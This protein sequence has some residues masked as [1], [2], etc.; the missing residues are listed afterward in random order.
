MLMISGH[1]KQKCCADK[2]CVRMFV[3]AFVTAED[4]ICVWKITHSD[5]G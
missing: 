2:E 5:T 4:G 3:F 1:Y